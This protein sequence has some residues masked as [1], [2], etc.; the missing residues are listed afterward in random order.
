M[1]KIIPTI[2]FPFLLL[3]ALDSHA[4]DILSEKTSY[5]GSRYLNLSFGLSYSRIMGYEGLTGKNGFGFELSLGHEFSESFFADFAYGFSATPVLTNNP[6]DTSQKVGSTFY[7]HSEAWR[8]YYK[9]P[10]LRLQPYIYVGAGMYSF[11][12]VDSKTGM[13]LPLG[14]Q[15]PFGAGLICYFHKNDL[16]FKAGLDWHVLFGENQSQAVLTYL[17]VNRVSFDVYSVMLTLTWHVF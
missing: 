4:F 16:S 3:F 11:S 8:F 14:F 12:S 17:N 13:D 9:Y 2:V 7:F 1:K 15:L 10:R 6:F 5:L